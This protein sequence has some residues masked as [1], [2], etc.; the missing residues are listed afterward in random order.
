MNIC[1]RSD[2]G[3]LLHCSA[4]KDRTGFGAALI[5]SALGVDE[6][7]IVRTMLLTN[8][9][10]CLFRFMGERMKGN[11]DYHIDDESIEAITGVREEYLRAALDEVRRRHG[12]VDGYLAGDR[13]RSSRARRAAPQAARL[14][15]P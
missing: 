3:F 15:S 7:T 10:Q 2:G 12:S 14:T 4:G 5:L 11:A 13:R 6:E 1:W 8:Q 9:A